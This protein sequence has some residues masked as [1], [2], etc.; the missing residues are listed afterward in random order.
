MRQQT[1]TSFEK[2][3]IDSVPEDQGEQRTAIILTQ[4]HFGKSSFLQR[5]LPSKRQKLIGSEASTQDLCP[6]PFSWPVIQRF[7]E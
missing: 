2:F 6:H 3:D 1:P 5:N 4:A 7:P